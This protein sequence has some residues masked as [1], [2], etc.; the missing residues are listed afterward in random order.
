MFSSNV[1]LSLKTRISRILEH[2]VIK[3]KKKKNR[4]NHK[5]HLHLILVYFLS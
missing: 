1:S 2:G 4:L 3:I 5:P